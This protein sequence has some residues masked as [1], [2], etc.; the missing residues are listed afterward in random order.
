V[1]GPL[2]TSS[3]L[4][5]WSGAGV[6]LEYGLY[7]CD[8]ICGSVTVF[9]SGL[10][11]SI[12]C[13]AGGCSVVSESVKRAVASELTIDDVRGPKPIICDR[14]FSCPIPANMS[15]N[16]SSCSP[17]KSRSASFDVGTTVFSLAKLVSVVA[18]VLA[19][20]GMSGRS[21]WMRSSMPYWGGS[22]ISGSLGPSLR[23]CSAAR[24]DFLPPKDSFRPAL[25]RKVGD[26]LPT[27]TGIVLEERGCA[28]ERSSRGVSMEAEEGR[29]EVELYRP[30]EEVS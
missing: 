13:R 19:N 30:E 3:D 22:W 9:V 16:P 15:A 1:S 24:C 2:A 4:V 27:L 25:C 10:G 11:A 23:A 5:G 17:P 6:A 20:G 12:N 28:C 29:V 26:L 14:L 18:L 7:D 21:T 8:C